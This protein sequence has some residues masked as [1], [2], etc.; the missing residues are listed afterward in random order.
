MHAYKMVSYCR[1]IT[2]ARSS[3]PRSEP[4]M[5]VRF[6]G[7]AAFAV[8]REPGE[9]GTSCSLTPEDVP[10]LTVPRTPFIWPWSA[11]LSLGGL[12]PRPQV[13][14]GP[15]GLGDG[16]CAWHGLAL[17]SGQRVF[18]L[19]QRTWSRFS[20]SAWLTHRS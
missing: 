20:L 18:P 16:S 17:L 10:A 1:V 11:T 7:E 19:Q 12:Q 6:S 8:A 5:A 13:V 9:A 2:R 4:C 3:G 14:L 15:T